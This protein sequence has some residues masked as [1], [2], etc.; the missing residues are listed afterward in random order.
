MRRRHDQAGNE[1]VSAVG[2]K[3]DGDIGKHGVQGWNVRD[4]ASLGRTIDSPTGKAERRIRCFV[5]LTAPSFNFLQLTT[6]RIQVNSLSFL[7]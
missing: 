2:L 4:D 1:F 7:H 3:D 5:S 6:V